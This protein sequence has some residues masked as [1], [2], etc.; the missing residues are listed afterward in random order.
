V[1]FQCPFVAQYRGVFVGLFDSKKKNARE[2]SK[3]IS[4]GKRDP[5]HLGKYSAEQIDQEIYSLENTK[6]MFRDSKW[7]KRYESVQK[8]IIDKLSRNKES[9][10]CQVWLGMLRRVDNQR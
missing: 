5:E 9:L 2:I 7:K 10:M 4:E 6:P 8:A 1:I 3:E